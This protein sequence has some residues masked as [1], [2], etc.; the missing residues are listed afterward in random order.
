MKIHVDTHS[1]SADS[2]VYILPLV[3]PNLWAGKEGGLVQ[4]IRDLHGGRSVQETRQLL[5][6]LDP[7]RF[8]VFSLILVLD[9]LICTKHLGFL[10][11]FFVKLELLE[12]FWMP[13]LTVSC[14]I[15]FRFLF[16]LVDWS[17]MFLFYFSKSKDNNILVIPLVEDK[18]W[19]MD[20]F[21]L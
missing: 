4:W 15:G 18:T 21:T 19:M 13:F 16:G 8:Q 2:L 11:F 6:V 10:I 17:W 5:N 3:Q 7:C 14:S 12:L 9:V 20:A 1:I